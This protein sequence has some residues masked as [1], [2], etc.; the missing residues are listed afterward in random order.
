MPSEILT[1]APAQTR[2]PLSASI[3]NRRTRCTSLS[4]SRVR[5]HNQ[6]FDAA[7]AATHAEQTVKDFLYP[8]PAHLDGNTCGAMT[9][10]TWATEVCSA[11]V[12]AVPVDPVSVALLQAQKGTKQ[13]K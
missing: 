1:S 5:Y 10:P 4:E 2:P 9:P 13:V 8:S 11:S 12:K 6:A 7:A 3:L